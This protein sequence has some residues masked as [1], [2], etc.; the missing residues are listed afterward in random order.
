M[1]DDDSALRSALRAAAGS[2]TPG[3]PPANAFGAWASPSVDAEV[4]L[5]ALAAVAADGAARAD[6]PRRSLVRQAA[7]IPQVVATLDALGDPRR[8]SAGFIAL[9]RQTRRLGLEPSWVVASAVVGSGHAL[10]AVVAAWRAD[11]AVASHPVMVVPS[12]E[13]GRGQRLGVLGRALLEGAAV[14]TDDLRG[15]RRM[16]EVFT[17]IDAHTAARSVAPPMVGR[18]S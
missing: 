2:A 13:L 4:A 9:A 12:P 17:A 8:A 14:L 6:V 11:E 18:A 10:N 15:A 5:A 1:V 7:P 16:L 3:S